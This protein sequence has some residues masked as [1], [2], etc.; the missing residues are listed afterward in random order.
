VK[1]EPKIKLLADWKQIY[2][3]YKE[4]V[5]LKDKSSELFEEEV[6]SVTELYL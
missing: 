5:S 4:V 3:I 2:S 1:N 6:I